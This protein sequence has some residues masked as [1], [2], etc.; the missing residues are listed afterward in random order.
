MSSA[1]LSTLFAILGTGLVVLSATC[2]MLWRRVRALS[3][4][5]TPI[6]PP[7]S[8]AEP[9]A[10][11]SPAWITVAGKSKVRYEVGRRL[12]DLTGRHR[13][14]EARLARIE[15]SATE[16]AIAIASKGGRRVDRGGPATSVGPTLIAVPN[17]AAPPSPALEAAAE[18]ESR[19]GD[20]WAMADAGRPAEAIARETGQPIGQVELILGLRRQRPVAEAWPDA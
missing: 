15:A 11:A 12:D 4:T 7:R 16:A 1:L 9:P 8:A 13:A 17:L 19:F 2:L 10:P 3:R 20:V 5:R 6:A 14:L 18:L